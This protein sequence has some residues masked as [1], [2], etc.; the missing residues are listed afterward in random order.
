MIILGCKVIVRGVHEGIIIHEGKIVNE[1]K[2]VHEEKFAQKSKN[3]HKEKMVQEGK[4]FNF[5][6]ESRSCSMKFTKPYVTY[7]GYVA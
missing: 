7:I 1:G 5:S 2:N 3:S 4:S 6:K